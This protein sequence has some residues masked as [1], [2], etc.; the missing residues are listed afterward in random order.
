MNCKN[1]IVKVKTKLLKNSMT[2]LK[3][4]KKEYCEHYVK[5]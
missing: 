2:M 5:V 4:Q 3:I 1:I